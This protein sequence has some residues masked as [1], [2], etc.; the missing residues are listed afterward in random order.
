MLVDSVLAVHVRMC[1]FYSTRFESL[2]RSES[3]NTATDPTHTRT[4]GS[5]E[6]SHQLV[7]LRPIS[8][9]LMTTTLPAAHTPSLDPA[10][11]RPVCIL[12]SPA[13]PT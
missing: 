2:A 7:S 1:F 9:S 13:P 6:H 3:H 5:W 8:L 4:H 12:V 11:V 10:S